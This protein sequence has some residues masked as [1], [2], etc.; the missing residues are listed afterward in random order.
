MSRDDKDL[1]EEST[2][3][4]GEHLEELRGCLFRSL[5]GL[6][7]GFIVGL[8]FGGNVV[9]FIQ[10]PLTDALEVYYQSKSTK[11]VLARLDQLRDAGYPVPE[12]LD[13]G[14]PE[15][16]EAFVKKVTQDKNLILEEMYINPRDLLRQLKRSDPTQ[17]ANI[18]EAATE[19][20]EP[21]D[22]STLAR[23]A[24]VLP[25]TDNCSRKSLVESVE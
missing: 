25:V 4:F 16:V 19:S 20:E 9:A 3:T 7:V 14:D 23:G 8:Y 17:F 11:D 22:T 6:A 18:P 12:D 5:T 10:T 21:S 2:M 15:A 24:G 13:S 1:F